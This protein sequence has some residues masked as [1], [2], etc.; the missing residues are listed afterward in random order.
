MEMITVDVNW[1]ND[2]LVLQ[3]T[4][5]WFFGLLG[6]ISY[7]FLFS[8]SCYEQNSASKLRCREAGE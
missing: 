2:V 4:L 1:L 7:K 8:L 3:I 6:V 5:S